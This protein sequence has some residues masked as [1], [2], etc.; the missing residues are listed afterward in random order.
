V[1]IDA[2]GLEWADL[3]NRDALAEAYGRAWVAALPSRS[4][5]FGLV[6]VEALACGTPVVG[7]RSGGISEI[8]EGHDVGRQFDDLQPEALA[9]ALLE[10]MEMGV[11]PGTASRC[12]NRAEDFSLERCT[13]S[14]LALY[15]EFGA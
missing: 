3:D 7:Y 9:G 13:D 6:L 10:V 5:A 11:D 1:A 4:E 8:I 12:R 15:R 2:P 14:Y